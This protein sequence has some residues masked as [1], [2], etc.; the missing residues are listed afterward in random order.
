MCV[1]VC[2]RV[3]AQAGKEQAAREQQLQEQLKQREEMLAAEEAQR[4]AL[5]QSS[6][7]E[8]LAML[9]QLAKLAAEREKFE[10]ARRRAS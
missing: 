3:C 7:E 10:K 9:E 8:N 1:C 2:A 4:K 5:Q 6:K